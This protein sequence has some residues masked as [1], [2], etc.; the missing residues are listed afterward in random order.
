VK[1]IDGLYEEYLL[2]LQTGDMLCFHEEIQLP[3]GSNTPY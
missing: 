2:V 1:N 3:E